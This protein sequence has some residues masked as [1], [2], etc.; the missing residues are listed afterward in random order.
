MRFVGISDFHI[1]GKFN[2]KMFKKGIDFVNNTDAD[3][4][5]L[6]GD[7]TDSGTVANYELAKE[8]LKEIKKPYLMV[9]GN[10]DSKNVGDL[11][12]EEIFGPRYFVEINNE[13]KVK[14]LGL[15]SSEPDQDTGRLDSKAIERIYLEFRDLDDSWL[16]VLVYHHQTLP[17]PYTGRE[18]SALIDAGDAIK[19][20]LDCNINLV[21]NGHRHISNTFRLSD[22]DDISSLI[23]NMGTLS[24]LKTRYREEYSLMVLDIDAKQRNASVSVHLL[25]SMDNHINKLNFKNLQGIPKPKTKDLIATI[26]QIGTTD[27]SESKFNL[28]MFAKGV[29]SINNIKCDLVVHCGNIT[30]ESWLSEFKNAKVMLQQISRPMIILPG[31]Q[32][33]KPLGYELFSNYIGDMNPI[34]E[35]ET[36][37][38]LGFNSCLLDDVSGRLGRSNSKLIE[39][40]MSTSNKLNIVAFHHTI[41]PLPRTRHEAELSDAGDVLAMLTRNK[42]DLVL[43]GAKNKPATWQVN[44]TV[45]VNTGTIS[46]YNINTSSGNSFNIVSIYQT[47][48][49]RYYEIDEV[50]LST[51]QARRIGAYHIPGK[52]VDI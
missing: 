32:D 44:D 22:G 10:H 29:K 28:N 18:R 52:A 21:F 40:K 9:P 51:E 4:V 3:Y 36:L 16:K 23:V 33:T 45:F 50:L 12:W 14:I 7:I 26:V 25:N 43:T 8:M 15:D 11:L 34:F 42:V 27:F 13:K 35:N 19:A 30:G 37:C 1:G 38:F 48:K 17:I 20:I 39:E 2:E 49:G 31:P 47:E 24:C 41:I 46:S 6:G 5:I